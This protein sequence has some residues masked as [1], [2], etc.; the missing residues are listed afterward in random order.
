MKKRILVVD[1][2][3]FLVT[4]LASTLRNAGFIVDEA[5]DVK[6][7]VATLKTEGPPDLLIMDLNLPDM[8]GDEAVVAL[9]K[10]P[11]CQP[12]AKPSPA[13]VA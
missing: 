5:S 10:V 3:Q 11:A 7:A 9:R 12:R 6:E 4:I 8:R 13:M 2:S 1:D